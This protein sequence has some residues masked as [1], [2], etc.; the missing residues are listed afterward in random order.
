M[1]Y[2]P[3]LS[4]WMGLDGTMVMFAGICCAGAVFVAVVMPETRGKSFAEIMELMLK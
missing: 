3:M 1:K 4:D 2:F